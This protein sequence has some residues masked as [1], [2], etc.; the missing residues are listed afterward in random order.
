MVRRR[1]ESVTL[2]VDVICREVI[3]S[4]LCPSPLKKSSQDTGSTKMNL[5]HL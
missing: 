3:H 2:V 4:V 1:L 5:T